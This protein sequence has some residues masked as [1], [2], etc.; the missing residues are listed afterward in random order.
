MA[1]QEP[2]QVIYLDH[3]ASTATKPSV[4]AA[5]MPH[6]TEQFANPHADD[7]AAGWSAAAAI[8]GARAAVGKRIGADPD[9]IIFT[10]GATEANNLAILG[11][12]AAAPPGRNLV[13]SAIEHK[14]VLGPA[15]ELARRGYELRIAPVSHDG[16]ADLKALSSMVDAETALVALMAVNNEIGTKQPVRE[17]A[18]ICAQYGALLHV[19]AAQALAWMDLDVQDLG[20]DLL[21]IS[22]HK[23]GGP[24]G[25]G[26][27]Y[28]RRDIRGRMTPLFFGGEQEGG[29]RPGTLPTPL[30]VGLGAACKERLS[31]AELDSWRS[32]TAALERDLITR[33]PG[34]RINGGGSPRHPGCISVTLPGVDAEVLVTRLQPHVALS[35]GS[36]CTSGIPEPSHVLRAI[37][38][39][40]NQ[41]ASTIRI[42]T[43]ATTSPDEIEEALNAIVHAVEELKAPAWERRIDASDRERRAES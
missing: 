37:G 10:S 43:T 40:A 35:R 18:T 42:G 11:I 9:E 24:K 34:A 25:V 1:I 36:A 33:I 30:C 17:A 27:L 39:E 8:E 29:L 31:R 7:H 2:R 12:A 23:A 13:V 32:R 26:A 6:L 20:A 19:D 15:R 5:M 16:V 41:I 3:Q 28:V 14:A 4:V 21:S 38:L 22:G